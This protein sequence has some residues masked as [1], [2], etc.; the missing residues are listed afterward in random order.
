MRIWTIVV[1][2]VALGATLAMTGCGHKLVAN[3]GQH[4]VELYPDKATYQRISQMKGQGGVAGMLG[5]L[6]ENLATKKVDDQTPVRI[7]SRDDA[8]AEVEV[9]AGPLKG[10]QGYVP[11]QN[12]D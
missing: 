4:E 9:T 8:G 12:L 7:I 11:K 1:C 6:G 2:A 10:D 3:P 5:G